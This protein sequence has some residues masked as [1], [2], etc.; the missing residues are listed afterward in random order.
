LLAG[1]Q[2]AGIAAWL[3]NNENNSNNE[4]KTFPVF[5]RILLVIGLGCSADSTLF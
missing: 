4:N 1:C 2:V 5:N 3:K